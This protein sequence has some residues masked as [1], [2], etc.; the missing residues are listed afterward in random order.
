MIM[1]FY[2]FSPG[3]LKL[4]SLLRALGIFDNGWSVYTVTELGEAF[5][6]NLICWS[7]L[8]VL[9]VGTRGLVSDSLLVGSVGDSEGFSLI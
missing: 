9:W 5:S 3:L 6:S 4:W 7:V 1:S 8:G 2:S